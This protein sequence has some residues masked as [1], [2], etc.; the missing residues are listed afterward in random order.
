MLITI[1]VEDVLSESVAR[2]L[3]AAY[4]SGAEVIEVFGLGGI[5]SVKSRIAE[6]N[7]RVQYLGPVLTLADLDRPSGCPAEVVQE[8]RGGLT[9]LP[10]MLI[11]VAVLEIEAWILADR[12]GIA[13]WL[14][15]ALNTIPPSPENLDDPKRAFVHLAARSRNRQLREGIAPKNVRGTHRVGPAYNIIVSEFVMQLWNPDAASRNSPSL[16]RAVN[17]IAE[18]NSP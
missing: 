16:Q 4:T 6:L 9:L 5:G 1:A 11:R 2:R 7:Q 8:L 3:I 13:Q 18:L 15:V 10:G 14:G 12:E 17:R